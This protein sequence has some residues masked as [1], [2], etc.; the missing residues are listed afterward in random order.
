M[1]EKLLK[2]DGRQW[3]PEEIIERLR[4]LGRSLESLEV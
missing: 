3:E 2:Y 1:K 4:S